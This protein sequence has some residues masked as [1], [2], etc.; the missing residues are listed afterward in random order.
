MRKAFNMIEIIFVIVIIGILAAVAIPKLAANRT[1]AEAQICMGEVGQFLLEA[2]TTYTR[3]G[4]SVFKSRK[5]SDI[6]NILT[7]TSL[8]LIDKNGL[9]DLFVDTT[10]VS[11]Y[12]DG[13]KIITYRGSASG[14]DYNLTLT[15][16]TE[17]SATSPIANSAIQSIKK[18]LLNNQILKIFKL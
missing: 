13:E 12:C 8:S 2:S 14:G 7:G 10:G 3:E 1:D 15:S 6:T 16:E 9:T 4:Y 5:S 18:N 11:Y 17:G